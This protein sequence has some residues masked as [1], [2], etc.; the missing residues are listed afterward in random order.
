MTKIPLRFRSVTVVTSPERAG[1]LTA[2]IK[3]G[4]HALTGVLVFECH[5]VIAYWYLNVTP[6]SSVF[7]AAILDSD[8]SCDVCRVCPLSKD[9]RTPLRVRHPMLNQII[10]SQT[11]QV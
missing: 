11:G 5:A 7:C 9:S 4:Q 3:R 1:F 6:L 10:N 2:F 8:K